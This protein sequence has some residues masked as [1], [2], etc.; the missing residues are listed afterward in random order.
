MGAPRLYSTGVALVMAEAQKVAWIVSFWQAYWWQALVEK[1]PLVRCLKAY[2]PLSP[3]LV[4]LVCSGEAGGF[5]PPRPL[6]VRHAAR[7]SLGL[8][9][10]ALLCLYQASAEE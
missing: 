10:R 1:S 7:G 2:H 8:G 3:P 9:R 6:S 4:S 5:Q